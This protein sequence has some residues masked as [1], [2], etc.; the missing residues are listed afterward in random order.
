VTVEACQHIVIAL[1]LKHGVTIEE[2]TASLQ[3]K[4]AA[5]LKREGL[6]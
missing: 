1:A 4:V 5:K 6:S 2:E 3:K